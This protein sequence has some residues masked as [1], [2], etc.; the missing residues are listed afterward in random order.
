MSVLHIMETDV[1]SLVRLV[2]FLFFFKLQLAA[3]I[4]QGKKKPLP[5]V[6]SSQKDIIMNIFLMSQEMYLA[7]G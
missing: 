6:N 1:Q 3:F 2:F 5:V 7:S 4:G